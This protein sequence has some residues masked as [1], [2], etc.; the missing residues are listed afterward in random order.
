MCKSSLR[1][2]WPGPRVLKNEKTTIKTTIKKRVTLLVLKAFILY[3][4]NTPHQKCAQ[5]RGLQRY[6]HLTGVFDPLFS[7]FNRFRRAISVLRCDYWKMKKI[8]TKIQKSVTL[9]ENISV[10]TL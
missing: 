1:S 10:C 8:K 4:I 3:A 9:L 5:F 2:D 6:V 7:I